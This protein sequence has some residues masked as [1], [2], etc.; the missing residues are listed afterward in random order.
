[1]GAGVFR[2]VIPQPA[3]TLSLQAPAALN[4]AQDYLAQGDYDFERKNYAQAIADYSQAIALDPD[5][6]EAYNNRAY[7]YMTLENYAL[8]LPD[9]DR[10]IELRPNYVNALMNRGDIYNY[11]YQIDRAR[12]VEDYDR[13]LAINPH[14]P[15]LCGHRMLALHNGWNLT[16]YADILINGLDSGCKR[17][18]SPD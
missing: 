16:V 14:V 11:Y 10:A 1:V 5:F 15:T 18:A 8:A 6:A 7:T 17:T 4:T 12:A 2:Q 13:V 3:P 9:L